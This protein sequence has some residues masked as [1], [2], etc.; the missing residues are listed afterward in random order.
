[1]KKLLVYMDSEWVCRE[2]DSTDYVVR[3]IREDHSKDLSVTVT[4]DADPSLAENYD[5][6]MCRFDIPLKTEF[7]KAV[8]KYD[9]GSRLFINPPLAKL[10]YSDK[11]YLERFA[12]T[13]ILPE[14]LI[15]NDPIELA[16][17]MQDLRSNGYDL[18]SKPIDG[19]GGKGIYKLSRVKGSVEHSEIHIGSKGRSELE[20]IAN[21]LTAQGSNTIVLQRFLDGI[22]KYGD[23]RV[24]TIFYEPATALLRM[25]KEGSFKGNV[26]AGAS[27]IKTY[28]GDRDIEI[29]DQIR[30]FLEEQK[31][32]WVGIDILGSNSGRYFGEVNFS[33]PGNLYEADMANEN[34]SG[35]EFLIQGIKDWSPEI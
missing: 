6:V 13:D 9:D 27:E 17:F 7:L 8:A 31:A 12:G 21:D 20:S 32:T 28:L 22:Q 4:G 29:V 23:T 1:M 2:D 10:Q 11:R 19:N 26:S 30:P 5:A 35:V 14:T 3:T 24:N 25:P 16:G 34:K 18:V 15:S 33:S